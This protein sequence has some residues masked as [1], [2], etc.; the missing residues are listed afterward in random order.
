MI[1][2]VHD[3]KTRGVVVDLSSALPR[4]HRGDCEPDDGGNF[5]QRQD[6]GVQGSDL[7]EYS[8]RII[9]QISF[10][11]I[12]EKLISGFNAVQ[13]GTMDIPKDMFISYPYYTSSSVLLVKS[14]LLNKMFGL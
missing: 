1:L 12:N 4:A 2:C 6:D 7:H 3:Y 13:Y 10:F 8:E 14:L 11:F 5:G 9:R